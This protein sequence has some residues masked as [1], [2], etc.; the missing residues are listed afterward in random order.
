MNECLL[1]ARPLTRLK[2]KVVT[3]ETGPL[4]GCQQ[5]SKSDYNRVKWV[6]SGPDRPAACCASRG[7][8]GAG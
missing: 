6:S 8:Q 7:S 3:V 1:C 5:K 2:K 4:E